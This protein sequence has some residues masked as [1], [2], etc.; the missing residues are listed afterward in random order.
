MKLRTYIFIFL[1]LT[2]I[3]LVHL[4]AQDSVI[5]SYT[6]LDGNNF[7]SGYDYP[8]QI[9][10]ILPQRP[11]IIR[12]FNI[13]LDGGVGSCKVHIY[14]HEGGHIIPSLKNDLIEPINLEKTM[15]GDT[16]FTFVLKDSIKLNNDQFYI[17]LD[18]FDGDFGVKQ[19]LNYITEFCTS[20]NGGDYFPTYKLSRKFSKYM[21]EVHHMA[22]DVMVTYDPVQAPMFKEVTAKVGLPIDV[23]NHSA[24]WTDINNDYWPDLLLGNKLYVNKG[25]VFTKEE[26]QSGSQSRKRTR[27]SA[28]ID[29][30]NDGLWD[31]I[32]FNKT[33]SW[34]YLNSGQGGFKRQALNIPAVPHLQ[35]LSISDIDQDKYPDLALA[36]LWGDYPEPKPNYLLLNDGLLNFQNVTS[37]L[38]PDSDENYN[39]PDEIASM[40]KVRIS[41]R[42]NKNRN[43]RSRA[44][45]F[46][47]YNQDGYDDL[48]VSNYFL[49]TDEFYKNNGNGYFS[50]LAAPKALRQSDS[51]SNN[52]TGVAWKDFDN[53]GDFDLLVPQLAHPRNMLKHDHRGTVLYENNQNV[54]TDITNLSGIQFEET[55]A[56]AD[57]GDVNNDGLMDLVTTVY[58]GCRFVDLYLQNPDHSFQ[59]S[60]H[61]SG[62]DKLATG[63]DVSYVDFN[64]DG[65]LDIVF[66][67]EGNFRL[68]EN[69]ADSKNNWIKL[70]LECSTRNRFGIGAIVKVYAGEEIY[71]QEV[72]AVK[73][74]SVQSLTTLHFGLGDNTIV[75]KVEVWFG[76]QRLILKEDLHTN[77][78]YL[79]TEEM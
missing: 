48:Y 47:D 45:Q 39:F 22:L 25:G 53:D 32:V 33:K 18:Q 42:P 34:L 46:I 63:S 6:T 5:S 30:N 72:S 74:Q 28:F 51:V 52:G 71:T 16:V 7:L 70:D 2:P 23:Y 14:G 9:A 15:V 73:G 3:T 37:R 62:F 19:D 13:Y 24:A 68:F 43:R 27:R 44:M 54:F 8:E 64:N 31:I 59:L 76:N 4:V 57:F 12:G 29:M 1:F 50:L 20:T 40:K 21:S 56:G 35:A 61:F 49:E 79:L 41:N 75:D 36:Q 60:T 67:S 78:A 65:K 11:C 55:H 66:V 77:R 58:Y 26:F 69:I 10:R 38:Y 17:T